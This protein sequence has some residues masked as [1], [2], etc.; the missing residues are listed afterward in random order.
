MLGRGISKTEY[1]KEM[2]TVGDVNPLCGAVM[3]L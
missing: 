1:S 3:G 2:V